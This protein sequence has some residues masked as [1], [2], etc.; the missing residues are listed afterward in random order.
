MYTEFAGLLNT[1]QTK[2]EIRVVLVSAAG[3]DYSAGNDLQNFLDHP[4]GSGDSPQKIADRSSPHLRQAAR[5]RSRGVAVASGATMLTYFDFVIAGLSARFQF[6]EKLS[7]AARQRLVSL[8]VDVRLQTID[9]DGVV[10][11]D[12]RVRAKT[13]VW[14]A[15]VAPSPAGK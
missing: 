7:E 14:T 10:L 15:G 4:P 1:A 2:S 8:G 5:R 9:A 6:S 12:E 3:D 13:V 11:G